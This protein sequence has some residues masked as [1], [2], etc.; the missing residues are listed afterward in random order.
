MTKVTIS[1]LTVRV[2]GAGVGGGTP[3]ERKR[4]L[5]GIGAESTASSTR[6]VTR[7]LIHSIKLPSESINIKEPSSFDIEVRTKFGGINK[8][9]SGI[10]HSLSTLSNK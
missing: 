3:S 4:L 5:L 2:T 9:P 1:G 10:P 6:F 7:I 8:S